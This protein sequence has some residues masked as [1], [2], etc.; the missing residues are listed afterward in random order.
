[1]SKGSKF[2]R[3]IA[4]KLSL[5]W[6]E[7]QS[8]DIFWRT[9]GSGARAK[10]RSKKNQSTFGQ[11]G[12]IQATNPIGQPLLDLCTIELKRGYSKDSFADILDKPDN[13][14]KQTYEKFIDQAI[15]D[16]INAKVP[17]WMLIVA[18]NRKKSLVFIS[19]TF[20]DRIRKISVLFDN[21]TK[22]ILIYPI[23]AIME[24]RILCM[25]LDDFLAKFT[26]SIVYQML[27]DKVE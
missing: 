22:C 14:K 23:S 21:C 7:G 19:H 27:E 24:C 1:M 15:Q 17:Y 5:W 3:E 12:D 4:K 2:E 25:T 18:R 11:Y 16:S 10:V 9:S 13:A 6:T 8:D 26:S 20:Y